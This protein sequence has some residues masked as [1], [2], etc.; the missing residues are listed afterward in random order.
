MRGER[1]FLFSN[2]KV[3]KGIDEVIQFIVDK[4]GLVRRT[5]AVA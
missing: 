5:R 2:L 4:G 1:P 3:N